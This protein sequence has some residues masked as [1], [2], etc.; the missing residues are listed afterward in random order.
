M[1]VL[2][3]LAS[4]GAAVGAWAGH[5]AGQCVGGEDGGWAPGSGRCVRVC[6]AD[7]REGVSARSARLLCVSIASVVV[8]GAK[9]L[10]GTL[11]REWHLYDEAFSKRLYEQRVAERQQ[12][13]ALRQQY[14]DQEQRMG[15]NAG[16]M[17]QS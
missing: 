16:A 4:T 10:R 14:K 1:C 13:Q 7:R 6:R 11:K 5:E 2:G 15:Q 12:V 8:V 9:K 17:H 3:V